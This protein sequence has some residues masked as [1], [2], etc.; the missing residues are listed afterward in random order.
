M[1][2]SPVSVTAA[3]AE[4]VDLAKAKQYLRIDAGDESFDD[5]V[6]TFI[7]ASRAEIE[8]IC[9]TRMITQDVMLVAS[10][11]ADLEH[12]PIGPVQDI[13]TIQYVNTD[14]VEQLLAAENYELVAGVLDAQIIGVPGFVWPTIA[15]RADA[16]RV[17]VSVG[18]GDA[19]TDV[20]RDLYFVILQAIRAKFEG[21]EIAIEHMLV[22]HRIWLA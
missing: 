18:Y 15:S 17:T 16:V 7:A 11:F 3:Q 14:G 4:P 12:L 19:S 22:N 20:P 9:N 1:W 2:L 13:V 6:E 5:E 10:S 21:R 8:Q